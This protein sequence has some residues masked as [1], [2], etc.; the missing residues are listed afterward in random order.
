MNSLNTYLYVISEIKK[1]GFKN[2]SFSELNLKE[3]KEKSPVFIIRHDVDRF[4]K[5]AIEMAKN[6]KKKSIKSIY[7][8]RKKFLNNNNLKIFLKLGHEVGLHHEFLSVFK[9]RK[10]LI[11]KEINII[12]DIFTNL[13][14]NKKKIIYNAHGAPFSRYNNFAYKINDKKYLNFCDDVDWN[15]FYYVTD[16][17]GKWGFSKFN[18]RD[19]LKNAKNIIIEQGLN[20]QELINFIKKNKVNK[21]VISAHPERWPKN[22]LNAMGY[23]IF[24]KLIN[25]IKKILIKN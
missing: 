6:E 21:I 10:N 2:I 12:S 5:F 3:K 1:L 24:D 16:V 8:F 19:Y 18:R 7:F 25:L 13:F 23:Y 14:K 15:G 20:N 4:N 11:K 9:N 22:E 17:G